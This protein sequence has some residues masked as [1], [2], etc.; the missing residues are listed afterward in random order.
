MSKTSSSAADMLVGRTLDGKYRIEEFIGRGAM[1]LVFRATQLDVEKP[2]A[3][4]IMRSDVMSDETSLQRFYREARATSKLNHPN[5]I[6]VFESGRFV[7]TVRGVGYRFS[8]SSH[9]ETR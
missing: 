5:T 2:V 3:L 6:K 7:E 9:D 1:G 4:K 8:E